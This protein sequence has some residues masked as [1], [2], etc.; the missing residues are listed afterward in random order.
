MLRSGN[1]DF[2]TW[3]K[4]FKSPTYVDNCR[5][6]V[7]QAMERALQLAVQ[8]ATGRRLRL[9]SSLLSFERSEQTAPLH[10][11]RA[12]VSNPAAAI[13]NGSGSETDSS[14]P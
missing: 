14:A 5:S 8:R 4:L 6:S 1:Q 10:A 9:P 11:C 13:M 12:C 3:H 2:L 7:I